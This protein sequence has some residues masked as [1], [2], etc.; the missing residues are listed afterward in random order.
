M[1]CSSGSCNWY[2]ATLEGHDY[3][4]FLVLLT[5]EALSKFNFQECSRNEMLYVLETYL[6]IMSYP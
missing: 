1:R 2:E 3:E 4:I 6:R 5:V